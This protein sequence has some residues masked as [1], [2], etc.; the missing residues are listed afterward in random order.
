MPALVVYGLHADDGRI[1]YVGSTRDP[2]KR[3]ATH[4][5]PDTPRGD[6]LEG[7]MSE[8][9]TRG[10]RVQMVILED[11]EDEAD[12]VDAETAWIASLAADGV[13]LLNYAKQPWNAIP[14][15]RPRAPRS[16]T[17]RIDLGPLLSAPPWYFAE[18][19]RRMPIVRGEVPARGQDSH[20]RQAKRSRRNQA[21][22]RAAWARFSGVGV[23][24]QRAT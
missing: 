3:L 9:A 5:S 18:L 21:R 7:W 1:R 12:R 10:E 16:Q 15:A 8:L 23:P 6:L 14:P 4:R 24:R 13:Q 17:A 22:D 11:V 20:E 2:R 19:A